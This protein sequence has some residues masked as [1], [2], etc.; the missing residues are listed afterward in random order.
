[1]ERQDYA[2][3]RLVGHQIA[4]TGASFGFERLSELGS[5]LEGLAESGE[6]ARLSAGIEELARYL[7][8]LP[9]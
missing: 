2:T 6:P 8:G 7:S 4:G 1:V 5:E 3:V 9:A